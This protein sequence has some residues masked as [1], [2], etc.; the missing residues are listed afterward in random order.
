MPRAR[1]DPGNRIRTIGLPPIRGPPSSVTVPRAIRGKLPRQGDPSPLGGSVE[2][3]GRDPPVNGFGQLASSDRGSRRTSVSSRCE[4]ET[5]PRRRVRSRRV[6]LA[7]LRRGAPIAVGAT[8]GAWSPWVL[9]QGS[10]EE[11]ADRGPLRVRRVYGKRAWST[12][13]EPNVHAGPTESV[14]RSDRRC[15]PAQWKK[16]K[17]DRIRTTATMTTIHPMIPI[18]ATPPERSM[19]W[20]WIRAASTRVESRNEQLHRVSSGIR[21]SAP[22]GPRCASPA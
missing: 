9:L 2:S 16:P 7:G 8:R 18:S 22:A 15:P 12:P 6:F 21:M 11:S 4:L 14:V 10:G 17:N 3:D 13:P 1:T 20:L 5:L 19:V